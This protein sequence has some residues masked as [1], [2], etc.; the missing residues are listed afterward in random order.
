MGLRLERLLT[1]SEGNVFDRVRQTHELVGPVLRV[2]TQPRPGLG[3]FKLGLSRGFRLPT[4]RDVTPRR[5]VPIEVSPTSPAQAGNPD[6]RPERAWSLDASW[7][8]APKTWAAD[9]V[10][11]ASLRRIDDVILD[12]LIEQPAVLTAP[13]LLQR[14]NAG[15]AWSAGLEV[16]LRGQFATALWS[17]SPLRWQASLALA[18]SRL[19][20]VAAERPAL[21]GQAAW[22]L[23]LDLTQ[24]IAPA[25]NAQLGLDARGPARADQPSGRHSEQAA[26]HH[27]TAGLGWQPRRGLSARLSVAQAAA[28]DAV[29]R[30]SVRVTE[31]GQPVSYLAREAWQ[32]DA[33]WRLGLDLAF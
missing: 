7:Q 28:S 16:E 17:A 18:R 3:S 32:T 9:L 33:T 12:R 24:A 31:A 25:W 19:D 6:L 10:L 2:S 5:Y 22:H 8:G 29:E 20:D 4:P 21:A 1:L 13:W 27:L 23:K 15:R 26:R 11:S 30:K 14:F